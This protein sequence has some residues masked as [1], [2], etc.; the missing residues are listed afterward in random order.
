MPEV[1]A[2]LRRFP[3]VR[4]VIQRRADEV[5]L[6]EIRESDAETWLRELKPPDDEQ[7]AIRIVWVAEV[8]D[9][10]SA[11][12]AIAQLEAEGFR[13][14]ADR[15]PADV[16]R[17]SRR[18]TGWWTAL[19]LGILVPPEREVGFSSFLGVR[20]ADLPTGVRA[21][22]ISIPISSESWTV[23]T[24]AFLLSDDKALRVDRVLREPHQTTM[25]RHG[26]RLT[27]KGPDEAQRRAV[28]HE[29]AAIRAEL[30][31]WFA[32]FP[33]A[34]ARGLA[35]TPPAMELMTYRTSGAREISF[36]R[37][38]WPTWPYALDLPGGERWRSE[39]WPAIHMREPMS[40]IEADRVLMLDAREQAVL[41]RTD[42]SF[43]RHA[44]QA[45]P[46]AIT[47]DEGWYVLAQQLNKSIGGTAALWALH[48]YLEASSER[49]AAARDETLPSLL[50]TRRTT[51]HLEA[52]HELLRLISDARAV[53]SSVEKLE[54]IQWFLFS[55]WDSGDWKLVE[56]RD[57]Q[58]RDL[59]WI[60][61]RVEFLPR[62]ARGVLDREAF[63]RD[64]V[65][66]ES[67]LISSTAGLR[68]A[69]QSLYVAL[70]AVAIALVALI[71]A[72][73][74]PD[75]HPAHSSSTAA[76]VITTT[77]ANGP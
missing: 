65:E 74:S 35:P 71:V 56:P 47:A 67:Q 5:H 24:C 32:K 70:I 44:N 54:P 48:C 38:P 39:R 27:F 63:T 7:V 8:L 69:S 22:L 33:G 60:R 37:L 68:V 59:R 53:A 18:G 72:L 41:I 9:P 23:L 36:E 64:R 1:P 29:R 42:E 43:V 20:N 30:T 4:D 6:R 34:F 49:F 57:S 11:N 15:S 21:A 45:P 14:H 26:W 58:D 62:A 51:R 3:V 2:R 13:D 55:R 66:I 77:P 10:G 31:E 17:R 16:V 73:F 28:R 19:D 61:R 25:E 40:D 50:T 46:R 12:A 76:T 52:T 75:S